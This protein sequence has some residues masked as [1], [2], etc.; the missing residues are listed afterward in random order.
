MHYKELRGDCQESFYNLGRAS[1][2]LSLFK[3]AIYF[4]E[5]ALN[6]PKIENAEKVGKEN[7]QDF[8][9]S[10]AASSGRDAESMPVKNFKLGNSNISVKS[11]VG[12]PEET[13]GSSEMDG[14]SRHQDSG[15]IIEGGS[16]TV[17]AGLAEE[18]FFKLP[19]VE[20]PE[21][22]LPGGLG[23]KNP[24]IEKEYTTLVSS[25]TEQFSSPAAKHD[26][27]IDSQISGMSGEEITDQVDEEHSTLESMLEDTSENTLF[28]EEFNE[29]Y[30]SKGFNEE[31]DFDMAAFAAYNLSLT[32]KNAK[33][34]T[35]AKYYIKK[36]VTI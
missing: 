25:Q 24:N 5:L 36:Y 14:A 27:N 16:D 20:D 2:Q 31:P 33:N 21:C 22:V 3:D 29:L 18:G 17:I 10:N 13:S 7:T 11:C 19:Y 35:G 4:Y 1:H 34:F 30:E 8:R 32:C 6:C 9:R 15:S 23:L 28:S 26:E 12:V